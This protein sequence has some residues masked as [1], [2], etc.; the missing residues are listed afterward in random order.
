MQSATGGLL[1]SLA[2]AAHPRRSHLRRSITTSLPQL[3]L[4]CHHR[5]LVRCGCGVCGCWMR[6]RFVGAGFC[7]LSLICWCPCWKGRWR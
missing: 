1:P 3:P 6:R 4:A 7:P 5:L 2:A